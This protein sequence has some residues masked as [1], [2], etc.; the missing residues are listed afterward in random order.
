MVFSGSY[1]IL[2]LYYLLANSADD[3]KIDDIFISI[4]DNLHAMSNSVFWENLI[5]KHISKCRLLK[6]LTRVLSVKLPKDVY[7]FLIV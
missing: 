6:I 5:R 2:N 7:A 1:V 3:K 4:G